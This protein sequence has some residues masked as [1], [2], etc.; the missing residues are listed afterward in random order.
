VRV[1][2]NRNVAGMTLTSFLAD[3]G[4]EMVS[5][6]LPGFL[7]AI[8]VS[9]AALGWI[10]GLAD[11]ASSFIKLGGGWYSDR[12]GRRK[13]LV[14]LGYFLSGTALALFALAVSWP[15]I[16]IGRTVAWFGKGIRGP[17]RDALLSESV[18]ATVRGKAFGF[19]RAG[20]T[21]GAVAGPLVGVWLLG[22]LPAPDAAAP[23]RWI[24]LASAVPGLLAV[25]AFALIVCDT[26]RKPARHVRVWASVRQLPPNYRR[27]LYG[28]GVF[29]LGE[30][31]T[32]S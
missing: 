24:F 5:A 28:V 32:H 26:P 8:G 15:L 4:Y 17:L 19:H 23:Y 16:L 31:S 13:G 6:V 22:L 2:L 30:F 20:D 10:E 21:V 18:P 9:A 7:D 27:F 11:A 29:G 14:S 12:I 3:V 25:A 1:W